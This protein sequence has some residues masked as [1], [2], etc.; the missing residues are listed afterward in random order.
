MWS[1]GNPVLFDWCHYLQEELASRL[2]EG[3]EEP[4]VIETAEELEA[5]KAVVL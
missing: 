5:Y 1:E 4:L 2:F 3:L